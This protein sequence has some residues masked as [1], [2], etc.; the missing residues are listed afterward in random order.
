TAFI[1]LTAFLC[2]VIFLDTLKIKGLDNQI[3]KLNS[4]LAVLRVQNDITNADLI[5]CKANIAKQNEAFKALSVDNE[6]LSRDLKSVKSKYNS[7]KTPK[8]ITC[9]SENDF[10]KKLFLELSK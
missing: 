7:L 1:L 10:Y 4:D 3:S 8:K 6:N 2:S 5:T 9:E